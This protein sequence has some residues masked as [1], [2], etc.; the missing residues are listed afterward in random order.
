VFLTHLAPKT[1]RSILKAELARMDEPKPASDDL[2]AIQNKI[3]E[4]GF[5]WIDGQVFH[6]MRALA[7]PIFDTQGAVRAVMSLVSNQASLVKFPNPVLEDLI[8]TAKRV[9]HRLGWQPM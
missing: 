1:T 6:G 3:R 9:S 7:A 2:A 5:A 8:A 4:Q